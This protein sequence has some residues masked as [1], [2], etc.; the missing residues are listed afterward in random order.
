MIVYLKKKIKKNQHTDKLNI[1]PKP[2]IKTYIKKM[3]VVIWDLS[4]EFFDNKLLVGVEVKT[5]GFF[6]KKENM[7]CSLGFKFRIFYNRLLV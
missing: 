2:K 6:L 3:W 4:L 5:Q 7:G 1:I